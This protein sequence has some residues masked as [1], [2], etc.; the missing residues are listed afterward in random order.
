[1]KLEEAKKEL[2][3]RQRVAN[4]WTDI[5]EAKMSEKT[6]QKYD[7]F[8]EGVD[9]MSRSGIPYL[10]ISLA[11]YANSESGFVPHLHNSLST[12]ELIDSDV[13]P[14]IYHMLIKAFVQYLGHGDLGAGCQHISKHL[15]GRRAA[16]K[17]DL[18]NVQI[19]L[20]EAYG[21]EGKEDET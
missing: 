6:R 15:D 21:L 1:M 5:V 9:A 19:Y 10:T 2:K 13:A 20:A 3:Q 4:D 8:L 11:P 12:D 17:S 14:F 7:K 16:E 18:E